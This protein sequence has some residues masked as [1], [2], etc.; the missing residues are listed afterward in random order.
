MNHAANGMTK[1]DICTTRFAASAFG[2][3]P[4]NTINITKAQAACA[5]DVA[6]NY[7][8]GF[9]PGYNAAKLAFTVA[10]GNVNF[11]QNALSGKSIVTFN[12]PFSGNPSIF[13]GLNGLASGYNVILQAA[14]TVGP[15][16]VL[17]DVAKAASTAGTVANLVNTAS[18]L[19]DPYGCRN[20]K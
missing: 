5:A 14:K 17:D 1:T 10:G 12:N 3:A 7:G 20:A 9:I 15:G 13:W 18:A 4:N 8:L 19:N 11:V 6:I 16:A 2:I